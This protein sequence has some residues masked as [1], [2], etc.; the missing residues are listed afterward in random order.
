MARILAPALLLLAFARAAAAQS[1]ADISLAQEVGRYLSETSAGQEDRMK[2]SAKWADGLR[3][4]NSDKSFWFHIGGMLQWDTYFKSADDELQ[5]A[6][7]PFDAEQDGTRIRRAR[8]QADGTIY[9]NV[10]FMVEVEF[11][12]SSP[13]MRNVWLKLKSIPVIQNLQMGHFKEPQGLEEVTSDRYTTFMERASAMGLFCAAYNPG[14]MTSG[15]ST[16]DWKER[17]TW[18]LGV[19]KDGAPESGGAQQNTD[20]HYAVTLRLTGIPIDRPED[21]FF[22]HAGFSFSYRDPA[23]NSRTLS[24]RPGVST[25]RTFVTVTVASADHQQVYGFELAGGWKSLYVQAEYLLSAFDTFGGA[26]EPDFSA[27]YVQAGWFVTGEK[28]PFNRATASWDRVRPKR[29]FRDG[30]SGWGAV[31]IV[32]RYENADLVDAGLDGGEQD[33]LTLGA[34]WYLNPNVRFMFN[35]ILADITLTGG[36]AGDFFAFTTRAHVDF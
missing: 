2:L 15:A 36:T 10:V 11:A 9:T 19:F 13:E 8:L 33:V 24:A 5:P 20:G 3:L 6:A 18:A 4:E 23:G 16:G 7:A 25:G 12:T 29:N 22:L 21:D 35:F 1:N 27:W 28:R 17:I 34:N 32:V 30:G 26:P 31:E 14:I